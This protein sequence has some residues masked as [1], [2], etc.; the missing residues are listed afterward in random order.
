MLTR[1]EVLARFGTKEQKEKYLLSLLS[2]ET[3]SSFSMTE[4][5]GA[6]QLLL[7]SRLA[8]Q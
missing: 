5:G 4:L 1:V 2:G 6:S 3:R 8:G 7:S